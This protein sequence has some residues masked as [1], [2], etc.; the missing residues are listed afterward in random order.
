MRDL[1]LGDLRT[2]LAATAHLS[3][4]TPVRIEV[5]GCELVVEEVGAESLTVEGTTR[6]H[7]YRGVEHLR[8]RARPATMPETSVVYTPA[9]GQDLAGP[10]DYA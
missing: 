2:A 5:D 9:P 4:D 3:H 1:S 8:L 7:T 10:D 6:G